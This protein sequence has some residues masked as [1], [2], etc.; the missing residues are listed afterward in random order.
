MYRVNYG[1]GQVS[2]T[3]GSIKAARE[4][5]AQMGMYR[6]FAFVQGYDHGDWMFCTT[7][8]PS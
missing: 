2:E 4:H 7:W 8:I 1:N 5:I 6:E 3:F